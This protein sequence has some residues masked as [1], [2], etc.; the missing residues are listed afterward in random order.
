MPKLEPSIIEALEGLKTKEL[1]K[2]I[3]KAAAKDNNFYEYLFVNY[4]SNENAEQDLFD[5]YKSELDDAF[6][7]YSNR[8]NDLIR[9]AKILTRCNKLIIDFSKNCKNKTLELNLIIY[10]LDIPFRLDPL[11]FDTRYTNYNY[12]VALLVK[13]A[14][15]IITTKIHEDYRIEFIDKINNYLS[16]LHKY[17]DHLDFVYDMPHSIE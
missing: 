17:S 6:D 5:K 12:R 16:I 2:L 13:K 4:N 10:V 8:L 15:T 1:V 11:M 9:Y 14:I 7:S 3:T